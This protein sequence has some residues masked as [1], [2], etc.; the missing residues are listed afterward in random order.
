[1]SIARTLRNDREKMGE[2]PMYRPS[3]GHGQSQSQPQQAVASSR[4]RRGEDPLAELARLIGQEDPFKEFDAVQ[5]RRVAPNGNGASHAPSVTPERRPS[6]NGAGHTNGAS[7]TQPRSSSRQAEQRSSEN[8]NQQSHAAAPAR[9][10]MARNEAYPA[11]RPATRAPMQPSATPRTNGAIARAYEQQPRPNG[12][13]AAGTVAERAPRAREAYAEET[14]RPAQAPERS[15]REAPRTGYVPEEAPRHARSRQQPAYRDQ[16]QRG[17][18]NDYDPEYDDEAYLPDHAEDIYDDVQRPGRGWGFW[19]VS[20]VVIASLIAV[21]FLGVFAYRTVFNAPPRAAVVTKSSVPTKVE[22][23]NTPQTAVPQSNK[24][25][26]DRVSGAADQTKVMRRE[27]T[28][29]DLTQPNSPSPQQQQPQVQRAPQFT[30]PPQQ[31]QQPQSPPQAV[32][33]QPKRVKTIAVRP[34]GSIV[35]PNSNPQQQNGPMN[36]QANPP[37]Q[38]PDTQAFPPQNRPNSNVPPANRNVASLGP[39]PAPQTSGNYI[40]QVA[41]HKT[42]E[43]AQGAWAN[44]RQQYSQIFAGRN[45]DIRKVDL[46]DRGTFYR[47]MVG[48]MNR[49]QANALC[50]NLKTQGAGCIVQ[51][52]N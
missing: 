10:Q 16:Y 19:L 32:D 44:L 51:T 52:R 24:P 23:N 35:Q 6:G 12:R 34:D 15:R 42:P 29:V 27:E 1:M 5:P 49:D 46:G 38:E 4:M 9:A 45:A 47:A 43:E 28:P 14:A 2:H 41:S 7:Y 48:P 26:Q 8:R 18:E 21:A 36:L 22:P 50:Q 31:Q 33:Q 25:I 13:S 39:T 3:R 20:G 11:P 40:V 37:Q 17:Y 30:A